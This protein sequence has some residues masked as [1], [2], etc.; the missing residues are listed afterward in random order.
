[1]KEIA[2]I[3]PFLGAYFSPGTLAGSMTRATVD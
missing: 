1:M 3:C 2:T